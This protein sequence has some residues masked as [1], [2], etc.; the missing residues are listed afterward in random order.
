MLGASGNYS[1]SVISTFI[2]PHTVHALH[3]FKMKRRQR[4]VSVWASSVDDDN[5]SIRSVDN[6]EF[7]RQASSPRAYTSRSRFN[8]EEVLAR[9]NSQRQDSLSVDE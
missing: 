3:E 8:R 5:S 6:E 4:L 7:S 1:H 9:L 2:D